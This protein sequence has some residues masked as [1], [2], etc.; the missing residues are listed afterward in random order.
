MAK[1]TIEPIPIPH[2]GLATSAIHPTT[3]ELVGPKQYYLDSA[4]IHPTTIEPMGEVPMM[5]VW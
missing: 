1:A 2:R 4:A 3:I 5:T